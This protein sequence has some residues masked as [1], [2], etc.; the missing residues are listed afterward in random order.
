M[1][2]TEVPRKV[3]TV[4]MGSPSLT[5]SMDLTV[6]MDCAAERT[7][8]KFS[9]V[10]EAD[11]HYVFE[12]FSGLMHYFPSTAEKGEQELFCARSRLSQQEKPFSHRVTKMEGCVVRE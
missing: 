5:V 12:L 9:I 4:P 8:Q 6:A 2:E 1:S 3:E 10:E 7:V 11:F